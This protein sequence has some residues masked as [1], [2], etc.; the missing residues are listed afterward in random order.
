[1]KV[2]IALLISVVLLAAW[3]RFLSR[4]A[5]NPTYQALESQRTIENTVCAVSLFP[6]VDNRCTNEYECS[7]E[8]D[9]RP[10]CM[11]KEQIVDD[12]KRDEQ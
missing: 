4:L 1:M 10:R 3:I 9:A 12:L 2:K 5:C 6:E 7:S 11:S 8:Q